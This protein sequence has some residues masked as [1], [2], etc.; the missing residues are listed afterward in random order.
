MN[1]IMHIRHNKITE[2]F[3]KYKKYMN[4]RKMHLNGHLKTLR[5]ELISITLDYHNLM[6]L[7]VES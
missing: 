6:P 7:G 4:V 3:K 2:Y 5:K 1:H